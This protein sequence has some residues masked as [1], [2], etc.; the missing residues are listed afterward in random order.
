M[1][2]AITCDNTT[3]YDTSSFNSALSSYEILPALYQLKEK[4]TTVFEGARKK[5]ETTFYLYKT[6][7][8]AVALERFWCW[9][10]GK[11]FDATP[12][13]K[14]ALAIKILNYVSNNFAFS[15]TTQTDKMKKNIEN[16]QARFEKKIQTS[17]GK[18]FKGKSNSLPSD[19]E[20]LVREVYILRNAAKLLEP[21]S[22]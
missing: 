8:L 3:K 22:L 10:T 15:H 2:K 6:N 12:Y 19:H 21:I 16:L 18:L 5:I 1:T 11:E 13:N 7:K 17:L 4:T 9:L 20:T 14:F